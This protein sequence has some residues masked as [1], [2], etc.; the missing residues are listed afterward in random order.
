MGGGEPSAEWFRR[1]WNVYEC[2]NAFR[3]VLGIIL[4]SVFI[5][6]H[7]GCAPPPVWCVWRKRG[8]FML[9]VKCPA[10]A[11]VFSSFSQPNLSLP[12]SPSIHLYLS[13]FLSLFFSH[14][15]PDHTL[16]PTSS[17]LLVVEELFAKVISL[18]SGR[19]ILK[20]SPLSIQL[21]I[22]RKNRRLQQQGVINPTARKRPTLTTVVT[23]HDIHCTDDDYED[24][25]TIIMFGAPSG[26]W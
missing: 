3:V 1:Q 25:N 2:Y 6:A 26:K 5:Y 21:N 14:L 10:R 17:R 15:S 7:R 23:K 18:P 11:K 9:W 12:Y 20:H 4:Y 8:S 16:H 19:F 13:F 22:A 24:D